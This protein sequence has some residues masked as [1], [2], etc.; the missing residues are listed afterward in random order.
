MENQEEE[1]ADDLIDEIDLN[2]IHYKYILY[3]YIISYIIKNSIDKINLK[4]ADER[5][6]RADPQDDAEGRLDFLLILSWQSSP[7]K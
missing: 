7:F 5:T 4:E 1:E 2:D 3:S 6:D